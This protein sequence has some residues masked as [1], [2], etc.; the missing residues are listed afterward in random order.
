MHCSTS[1]LREYRNRIFKRF[2]IKGKA[3]LVGWAVGNKLV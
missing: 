3:A 2:G 1:T